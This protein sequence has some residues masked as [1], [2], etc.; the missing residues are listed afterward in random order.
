MQNQQDLNN[1][2]Q[3][4][5]TLKTASPYK[6]VDCLIENLSLEV[7][8]VQGK[9][10]ADPTGFYLLQEYTSNEI[11]DIVRKQREL[12]RSPLTNLMPQ[13]LD[14]AKHKEDT[15]YFLTKTNTDIA[16][17]KPLAEHFST[18]P[19]NTAFIAQV[20]TELANKIKA[21]NSPNDFETQTLSAYEWLKRYTPIS[22]STTAP[23]LVV[24]GNK[25]LRNPLAYAMQ[26]TW[27]E[28]ALPT[29]LLTGYGHGRLDVQHIY[30]AKGK[31]FIVDV[32]GYA[33]DLP[34][35]LDWATLELSLLLEFMPLED[36]LHWQEWLALCSS[37]C[38]DLEPKQQPIGLSAP[39]A[40]NLISPLRKSIA[41]YIKDIRGKSFRSSVETSYW[42]STTIAAL[43]LM[44]NPT[45]SDAKTK[46][47]FAY[48]AFAFEQLADRLNVPQQH[49]GS[50]SISFNQPL[51]KIIIG[52]FKAKG[53]HFQH[54]YALIIG[55]GDT[56]DP[57]KALPETR[58][59]AKKLAAF[60]EKQL[61]YLPK[62]IKLLY[63]SDATKS[64]IEA[65]FIWLQ[66]LVTQDKNAT[67][68]VYYSGHGFE[69]KGAES[70]YLIPYET[71]TLDTAIAVESFN[72]WLKNTK[73]KRLAVFLDCCHA[74]SVA[75]SKSISKA[76]PKAA[77]I[78]ILMQGEG[79]A[80]VTSSTQYQQSY[81]LGGHSNSLFT[82]VLLEALGQV[83]EVEVLDVFKTLRQEVNRRAANAS[84][85]Q[86]PRFS[87]ANLDKIVLANN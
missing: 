70:Y 84:I 26:S 66:Q 30:E 86:T 15:L 19:Y 39:H 28:G 74:G 79:R 54:G 69:I 1:I 47:A 57:E 71:T 21:W 48:G 23:A 50:L 58:E 36:E 13:T 56:L 76:K 77:D 49:E 5:S 51:E 10:Q 65:G 22:H 87:A 53:Q 9:R 4:F 43:R 59:D 34:L 20:L 68:I 7:V 25:V 73:A 60:L 46:A 81:I 42:L 32:R 6:Q 31:P 38:Q 62:N 80:L 29:L 82:E 12:E 75:L 78:N 41:E 11:T 63:D 72:S 55:V 64:N 8:N 27:W 83:G 33:N 67:A 45:C 16:Y 37:I 85:E 3:N 14:E 17:S 18:Q 24:L 61:G 2:L 40:I 44:A 52:N 35:L